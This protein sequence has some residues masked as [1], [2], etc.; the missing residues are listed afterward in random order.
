MRNRLL[1][2]VFL[3]LAVPAS[4][5]VYKWVDEK[6]RTHYGEKPP[7]GVKASEMGA[8]TP[9][10]DPTAKPADWKQKELE[11][12]R[13]RIERDSRESKEA[14]RS[15]RNDADRS[16]RCAEARRRLAMLQEQMRLFDRNDKGE[17][18]YLDDKDRPAAMERERQAIAENC[19]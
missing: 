9:P 7:E 4:A 3:A 13:N 12:K 19:G 11:A 2:A 17:K 15:Q 14:A 18:V 6:G 10:S 1:V 16:R 8:P 5:Q